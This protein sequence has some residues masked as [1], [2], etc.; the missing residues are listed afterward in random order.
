MIRYTLAALVAL[1]AVACGKVSTDSTTAATSHGSL[2]KCNAGNDYLNLEYKVTKLLNHHKALVITGIAQVTTGDLV[3]KLQ[4]KEV[5]FGIEEDN[6]PG[7]RTA[8]DFVTDGVFAEMSSLQVKNNEGSFELMAPSVRIQSKDGQ[9]ENVT[10]SVLFEGNE[11]GY[12]IQCP[13]KKFRL[14]SDFDA[15]LL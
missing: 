12:S 3:N 10:I 8:F 13:G 15:F 14:N 1:S 6:A 11:I 7:Q 5:A 9:V 4:I 2:I